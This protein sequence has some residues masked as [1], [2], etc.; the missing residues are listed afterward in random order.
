MYFEDLNCSCEEQDAAW[1]RVWKRIMA[2]NGDEEQQELFT[3]K[4]SRKFSMRTAKRDERR[5]CREAR[6]RFSG[7]RWVQ[8]LELRNESSGEHELTLTTHA[9]CSP[10]LLTLERTKDWESVRVCDVIAG[11]WSFDC[12]SFTQNARTRTVNSLASCRACSL[13]TN[14][15]LRTRQPAHG[16]AKSAATATST[17]AAMKQ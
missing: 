2:R 8:P 9:S 14:Q 13:F 17:R 15:T 7:P 10:G 4:G 1:Y 5:R 12:R 6:T 3:R 16:N 11:Y